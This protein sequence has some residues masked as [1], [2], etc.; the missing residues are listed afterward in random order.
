MTKTLLAMGA[1]YDDCVF[2]IPGIMLQAIRKHYRVVILTLIGDYTNWPPARGR[3]QQIMQGTKDICK[4]YGAE[5]RYL[6]FA[7]HRYDVDMKS[8]RAVAEAVA[9]I[10]ADIALMLWP[11]D[12]HH[13]H[14]IASDLCKIALRHGGRVLD[15]RQ[16]KRPREI[17]CYDNGP[18]HT[19]GFEADTYVNVTDEWATSMEWLGRFMALV[20]GEEFDA[21]H[22]HSA[23]RAKEVLAR[24]RGATCGVQYA[25][26]IWSANKLPRD[27]L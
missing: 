4:E 7:S 10:E 16:V 25:E 13:D 8:K 18:R 1:H 14:T 21:K 23:Q 12:H 3:E 9:E 11:H 26:A 22:Q 20:R 5:M 27:I 24:Y 15:D 17:Y 2:G 6:D 19:I